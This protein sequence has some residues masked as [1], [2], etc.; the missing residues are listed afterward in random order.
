MDAHIDSLASI[1]LFT[2]LGRA[3]LAK[4]LEVFEPKAVKAGEVL[5][6]AGTAPTALCILVEGALS[7]RNETGEVLGVSPPQPIG[8]LSALTG[9]DRNLTAVAS[10]PSTLLA[11]PV[12]RFQEL[13]QAD[14]RIGFAILRNVMRVAARKIGRDRRRLNEMRE[15][16]V[17]TQKAMKRMREA[18]LDSEDTPLHV[19]LFEQ[20]DALVEQN[21]KIHY[22]VEPSRMVPTDLVLPEGRRRVTALSREWLYFSDPPGSVK[23]GEEL[24]AVLSLDGR[25]IPISGRVEKAA[26]G[27]AAVYLDEL[28]AEYDDA[29]STHLS[30]AQLLDVVL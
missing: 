20:L 2:G 3:D 22:L 5:F 1:S 25:E 23:A 13:L 4:V 30:R 8:E 24:R 26:D 17:G 14:G 9:E 19:A 16:I 12:E 7:I 29:F 27:E 21:R 11:A 15:N 28:I 18:L 10:A 6:E